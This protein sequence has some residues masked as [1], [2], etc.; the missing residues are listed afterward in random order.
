LNEFSNNASLNVAI[1]MTA[2]VPKEFPQLA[3]SD[4][5][6]NRQVLVVFAP[7]QEQ[8]TVSRSAEHYSQWCSDFVAALHQTPIL[9][10]SAPIAFNVAHSSVSLFEQMNPKA[11]RKQLLPAVEQFLKHSSQLSLNSAHL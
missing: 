6:L 10:L 2:F 5:S 11:T 8:S 4:D 9:Q 1:V 3:S 7:F